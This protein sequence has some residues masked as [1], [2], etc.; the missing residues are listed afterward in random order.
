MKAVCQQGKD[1]LEDK[2]PGFPSWVFG[3]RLN[4]LLCKK[5]YIALKPN[6]QPH[7]NGIRIEIM[8]TSTRKEKENSFLKMW[9]SSRIWVLNLPMTKRAM[10]IRRDRTLGMVN[11]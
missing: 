3:L 1:S 4:P 9:T 10:V 7:R 2:H 8:E 5:K 6:N 11:W